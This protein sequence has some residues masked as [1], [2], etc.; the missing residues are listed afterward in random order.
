MSVSPPME[1]K[2]KD[3][4]ITARPQLVYLADIFRGTLRACPLAT[5]DVHTESHIYFNKIQ[6]ALMNL[7]I[8]PSKIN[9]IIITNS[10]GVQPIGE[11]PKTFNPF[12]FLKDWARICINYNDSKPKQRFSVQFKPDD[13]PFPIEID[14]EVAPDGS[15]LTEVEVE[16]STP[17][18]KV[19][20]DTPRMGVRQLKFA[21]KIVGLAGFEQKTVSKIEVELKAKLKPT[22]SFYLKTQGLEHLK[23]TFYGEVGLKYADDKTKVFGGGGVLFEMPFDITDI[24][25]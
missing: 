18:K 8:A 11:T 21:T 7:G 22:L 24:V 2:G 3:P 25:K 4:Q 19:I 16:W 1:I 17:I 20:A 13:K 15:M 5:L 10:S 12:D 14:F 23:I 9:P 6:Q